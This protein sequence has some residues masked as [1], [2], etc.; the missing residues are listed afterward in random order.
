MFRGPE[1]AAVWER[2]PPD[3]VLPVDTGGTAMSAFGAHRDELDA[4]RI[5]FR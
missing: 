1:L 3:I 4:D 2:Y 5:R